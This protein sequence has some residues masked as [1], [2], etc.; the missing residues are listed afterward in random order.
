MRPRPMPEPMAAMPMPSGSPSA[1]AA[2][3]FMMT[4]PPLGSVSV[5]RLPLVLVRLVRQHEEEV[6]R[7]EN[8]EH[9]GLQRARE[10]RQ[11]QERQLQRQSDRQVQERQR[12]DAE[13]DERHQQHVLAEDVSEQTARQ[14][15]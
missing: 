3:K 10:Q 11:Q 13:A 12:G 14:R 8:H 4:S 5:R 9:R 1:R 15:N 2:W 7:A 6:N